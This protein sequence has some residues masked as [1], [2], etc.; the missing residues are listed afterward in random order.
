MTDQ[1]VAPLL[2]FEHKTKQQEQQQQQQKENRG[3]CEVR[4]RK[5][6]IHTLPYLFCIPQSSTQEATEYQSLVLR[7]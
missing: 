7:T 5:P 6:L 4:L 2:S 3:G 1:V